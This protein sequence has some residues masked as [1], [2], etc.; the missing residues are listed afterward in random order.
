MQSSGADTNHQR[1]DNA[2]SNFDALI[3]LL[4][5]D[6]IHD[7]AV[8][9]PS[10][11]SHSSRVYPRDAS[12]KL[13]FDKIHLMFA[14]QNLSPG[15]SDDTA[16]TH[17]LLAQR[18]SDLQDALSRSGLSRSVSPSSQS[19]ER[20]QGSESHLPSSNSPAPPD[21]SVQIRIRSYDG[22]DPPSHNP[23]TAQT[24]AINHVPRD[25]IPFPHQSGSTQPRGPRMQLHRSR[26]RK[27]AQDLTKPLQFKNMN[28]VL[29]RA[30]SEVDALREQYE[31]LRALVAERLSPSKNLPARMPSVRPFVKHVIFPS[32]VQAKASVSD[33]GVHSNKHDISQLSEY[34]EKRFLTR[35]ITSL[36]LPPYS[37]KNLLSDGPDDGSDLV[38]SPPS[39][40]EDIKSSM[41][42]L[43]S[44][45]ELVWKRSTPVNGGVLDPLYSRANMDT[46]VQRLILWEKT[47]RGPHKG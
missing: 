23:R 8:V 15:V 10:D 12:G 9:S 28:D 3:D 32:Q 34:E 13:D 47:V 43:A 19:S 41:D 14:K 11:P 18:E 2:D 26:L 20:Q 35:L 4:A 37:I 29:S 22:N 16:Q 38:T 1:P 44:V 30:T 6:D 42:F 21:Q 27:K 17:G 39:R 5:S 7:I 33:P 24:S 46:L 25:Q 31:K 40:V 36:R 45:D